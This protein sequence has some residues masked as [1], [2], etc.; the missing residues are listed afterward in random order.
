[1]TIQSGTWRAAYYTKAMK[2][3]QVFRRHDSQF[4]QT[5]TLP[6]STRN[7]M[8]ELGG[9]E[10]DR[11]LA[12]LIAKP[13]GCPNA[14]SALH[15]RR[16]NELHA[17]IRVWPGSYV[18]IATHEKGRANAAIYI[19]DEII[20]KSAPE[21]AF[22]ATVSM[23]FD[24]VKLR[25]VCSANDV[26]KNN[27]DWYQEIAKNSGIQ[28]LVSA[29]FSKLFTYR[30]VTPTYIEPFSR[31]TPDISDIVIPRMIQC[32]EDSLQDEGNVIETMSF[33][34]STNLNTNSFAEY[35]KQ[36]VDYATKLSQSYEFVYTLFRHYLDK[37]DGS[38]ITETSF[39][40]ANES[41]VE[42]LHLA[43]KVFLYRHR[44]DE[45]RTRE[46]DNFMSCYDPSYKKILFNHT[47]LEKLLQGISESPSG[48]VL[49]F[50][51]FILCTYKWIHREA[52]VLTPAETETE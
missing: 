33:S 30:C 1:M 11:G 5:L 13:S 18:A 15:K 14:G 45:G 36:L 43:K 23:N 25:L 3:I 32:L 21:E 40:V 28:A 17:T 37:E 41:V 4:P 52:Q 9:S 38:L 47:I 8:F 42:D 46:V 44:I 27:T 7:C 12:M 48:D 50:G 51:K 10:H 22:S 29:L 39:I 26:S 31:V 35:H 20:K 34:A 6:C 19:V 16:Y 2:I 24:D 49:C